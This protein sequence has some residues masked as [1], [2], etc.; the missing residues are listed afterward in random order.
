MAEGAEETEA[1]VAQRL[2]HAAGNGRRGEQE[3]QCVAE[4]HHLVDPSLMLFGAECFGKHDRRMSEWASARWDTLPFPSCNI[5]SL[6]NHQFLQ[7]CFLTSCVAREMVRKR[8]REREREGS[9]GCCVRC[10]AVSV[11][12]ESA[13]IREGHTQTTTDVKTSI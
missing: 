10:C 12:E 8:E 1:R 4:M 6:L 11:S 3:E 7:Q 2:Q 5:F 9:E 13:R